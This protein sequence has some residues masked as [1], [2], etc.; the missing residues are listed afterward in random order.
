MDAPLFAEGIITNSDLGD[1]RIYI[2]P[3]PE[4]WGFHVSE[5]WSSTDDVDAG[6]VNDWVPGAKRLYGYLAHSGFDV[7]WKVFTNELLLGLL[8]DQERL[9]HTIEARQSRERLEQFLDP[10]FQEFG[11]SGKKYNREDVI[12]SL[13]KSGDDAKIFSSDFE[14]I[15]LGPGAATLLYQSWQL[16][17]S[18]DRVL[19]ARRSSVWR[20]ALGRW[21]MVFHQGTSLNAEKNPNAGL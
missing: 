2:E 20:C 3:D 6:E 8:T 16:N 19:E 17:L 1:H 9:L 14:L 18:G 13:L 5:R 7:E 21:S 10:E 4:G 11:L 15:R 12:E